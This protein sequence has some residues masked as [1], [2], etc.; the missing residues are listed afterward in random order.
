[1]RPRSALA[2]ALA[3]LAG[4]AHWVSVP[5]YGPRRETVRREI[6]P[7]FVDARGGGRPRCAQSVEIGFAQSY[8]VAARVEGRGTDT[9]VGLALSV[10]GLAVVG[11]STNSD[12]LEIAALR[13][14][15]TITYGLGGAMFFGGI[16]LITTSHSLLPR[17]PR[18][19]YG[20]H[21]RRGVRDDVVAAAGCDGLLADADAAPPPT[22]EAAA[23]AARLRELLRLR[24][25]GLIT[26][27]EY[28]RQR[29][30]ALTAPA[31]V[32]AAPATPRAPFDEHA[33]LAALAA[34][35]DAVRACRPLD[36]PA[37]GA[38][39]QVVFR[40]GGMV[41]AV[42]VLDGPYLGTA[43]ATCIED[44]L[45]PAAVPP[46]DGPPAA[47]IQRVALD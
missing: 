23:R 18:P 25:E 5:T 14:R 4:C 6:G 11:A 47:V 1:M 13:P 16:A 34:R 36:A 19:A 17:G 45:R 27:R 22:A 24:R 21:E 39:V 2:A 7:P 20:P 42:N 43:T 32:A 44:A 8:I 28:Q 15:A 9:L 10:I 3:A 35:T 41:H 29:R 12:R 40:P 38:R 46:F 37:G 31:P 26:E 33:A 30:A